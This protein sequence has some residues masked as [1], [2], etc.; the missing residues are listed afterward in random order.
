VAHAATTVEVAEEAGQRLDN[1]LLRILKNVPKSRVYRMIRR[2]EVRVNGGRKGPT[3]RL[4][5][6]DRVRV[7][8]YRGR[9]EAAEPFVGPQWLAQLEQAILYEDNQLLVIDK[10]AGL[11]VH[12]GSGIAFGVIEVLRRLRGRHLELAHRLDRDTSGCLLL[13][14]RR[15]ALRRVHAAIREGQVYKR[16]ELITWGTWPADLTDVRL[17]LDRYLTSGGERRV[18]VAAGGKPSHT[19]FRI[20]ESAPRACLLSAVL[21]TG[22]THQIRVHA[23]A[24]GCP[25]V[26]DLK[27]AG[28]TGETADRSAAIRRLCL[29]AA[30][31]ALPWGESVL[32]VKSERPVELGRIWDQLRGDSTSTP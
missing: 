22:R 4:A 27:Y 30:E 13:V 23:A 32:R 26:G 3:Y 14:K 18:R 24:S 16:Y 12:G 29:H 6:G 19:E 5:A 8:P 9:A 17:P 15:S 25:V 1:F 21:H 31:L 11:A 20:V 2:G 10:P 28:A 7:P